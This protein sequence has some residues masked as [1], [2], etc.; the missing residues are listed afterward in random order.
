M[1]SLWVHSCVGGKRGRRKFRLRFECPRWVP[2]GAGCRPSQSLRAG[3]GA[4]RGG[5]SRPPAAG[6]S[7]F[8]LASGERSLCRALL[9]PGRLPL[10]CSRSPDRALWAGTQLRGQF[11]LS[12][13]FCR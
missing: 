11:Q 9:V 2:T 12:V 10:D 5:C 8:T 1:T 3:G 6:V 13:V 7:R 4:G